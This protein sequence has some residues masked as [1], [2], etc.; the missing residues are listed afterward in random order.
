MKDFSNIISF[1]IFRTFLQAPFF[2][3]FVEKFDKDLS[4]HQLHRI[5]PLAG[6]QR[7]LDAVLLP[8]HAVYTKSLWLRHTKAIP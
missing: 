7:T 6:G 4:R 5:E 1:A 8:G 3:T 2:K